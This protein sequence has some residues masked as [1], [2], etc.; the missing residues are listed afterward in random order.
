[1]YKFEMDSEW[2]NNFSRAPWEG[3]EQIAMPN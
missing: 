1:M 2:Y 3:A